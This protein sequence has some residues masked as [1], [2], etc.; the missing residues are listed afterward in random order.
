MYISKWLITLF[1]LFIYFWLHSAGFCHIN[2]RKKTRRT[3][4]I[5]VSLIK[6]CCFVTNKRW[7]FKTWEK[8][9]I[10]SRWLFQGCQLSRGKHEASTLCSHV[11]HIHVEI[12]WL[13]MWWKGE[14]LKRVSRNG[15]ITFE[16]K[17]INY[18]F[19]SDAGLVFIWHQ[20]YWICGPWSLW[21]YVNRDE[22]VNLFFQCLLSVSA[23]MCL[24]E[25][26]K[27]WC[28]AFVKV[29]EF[30]LINWE[31]CLCNW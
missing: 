21:T 19:Q 17:L 11:P 12:N 18:S 22:P 8:L 5:A 26:I 24:Y 27:L 23:Q 4:R 29:S 13:L 9:I 3:F 1:F 15:Y 14:N 31:F 10:A 16:Q 7:L 6:F 20:S 30:N 2:M 28:A 25:S